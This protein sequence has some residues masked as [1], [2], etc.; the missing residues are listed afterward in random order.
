MQPTPDRGVRP[1]RSHRPRLPLLGAAALGAGLAAACAGS[2]LGA[3]PPTVAAGNASRA[4][5]SPTAEGEETVCE[6]AGRLGVSPEALLA[7]SGLDLAPTE[8]L[9]EGTGLRVPAHAPLRHRIARGETVWSLARHYGVPVA[10]LVEANDIA[11]PARIRAGTWLRIPAGARTGCPPAPAATRAA[12]REGAPTSSASADPAAALAHADTVLAQARARYDAADFKTA[13]ELVA[14][15]GHILAPLA[16]GAEVEAL[17]ARAAWLGGLA[18][19]GLDRPREAVERFRVAAEH[20]ASLL[21]AENVS[22]KVRALV[23][24][25]TQP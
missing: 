21:D 25:A 6:A 18:L 12:E 3:S 11:D 10:E 22:P 5:S 15:A 14:A 7:A 20:D 23:E 19:T 8:R 16:E 9:A 1:R 17:R 13:A 2:P 24:E 4:S